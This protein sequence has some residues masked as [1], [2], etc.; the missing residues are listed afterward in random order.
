MPSFCI[1]RLS[2]DVRYGRFRLEHLYGHRVRVCSLPCDVLLEVSTDQCVPVSKFLECLR[3]FECLDD[4]GL[5]GSQ[6]S[7]SHIREP[8]T[9]V[10]VSGHPYQERI[11]T[12][13]IQLDFGER[14]IFVAWKWL[15]LNRSFPYKPSHH[16]VRYVCNITIFFACRCLPSRELTVW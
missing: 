5:G 7:I 4:Y 15:L 2:C 1:R 8:T 3:S 6:Q 9:R 16:L 12:L 14:R 10:F 11:A 13:E